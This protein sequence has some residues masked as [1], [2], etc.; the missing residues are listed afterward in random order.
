MIK[1]EDA[2]RHPIRFAL[3]PVAIGALLLSACGS[4]E[5]AST[6]TAP[7]D[8]RAD[9]FN[10]AD[11]IFAQGMIPHHQQAIEMAGYA[12]APEAGASADIVALATAIQAAQDPE[13][14]QMQTWLEQWGQPAEMPGMEGMSTDE[15]EGMD[16]MDGMG[17][18][19]GMMSADDMANLQS[20]TGAEFDTAW[21]Q[22]MIVHHEGAI[23]Q[24]E[25]LKAAGT[26][27][28]VRL[29]ADQIIAAQQAEIDQMRTLLGG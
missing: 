29:L 20:L 11:V 19:E 13:I 22:M 17:A 3:V 7:T 1:K 26:N 6:T 18:M 24:A 8:A 5:A 25:A 23:A 21:A 27:P 10:D 9:T 14:Q 16:G 4:D 28:D 12:L 2:V 15:M